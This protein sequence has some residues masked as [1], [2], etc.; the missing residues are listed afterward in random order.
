MRRQSIRRR[1]SSGSETEEVEGI[2]ISSPGKEEE[3]T[4]EWIN[5][6]A[7]SF[8]AIAT[9]TVPT[10]QAPENSNQP[11]TRGYIKR[12]SSMLAGVAPKRLW[13]AQFA[14]KSIPG[15][16]KVKPDLIFCASDPLSKAS[17]TWMEV[18]SFMEV[19]SRPNDPNMTLNLARKAYA[20]FMTQPGRRFLMAVSISAQVFRLHIY[21]RSGVIHSLGYNIHTHADVFSK[22]IYFFTFAQPK[23]LGYDP[24]FIYFDIPRSLSSTP[25]TIRVGTKVYIVVRIIFYSQLIRGRATLCLHVRN[26]QG[27]D[28]VVKDC[29]THQGRKVTEEQILLKLKEHGIHGLPVLKEAWTVQIDGQDDTTDLRRPD[30]LKSSDNYGAMCET[31]I[32]RRYLLQPLGSPITEF[33]CLQEFLSI[34]INIIHGE[35]LRSFSD[36]LT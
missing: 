5:G 1:V 22:L 31:R 9:V 3:D 11:H 19:T 29:W 23:A 14:L 28:F 34:F 7:M 16:I 27:E 13:S 10:V 36:I 18:M 2:F 30:F 20:V 6:L 26:S 4:A 17:P 32:H 33:S 15:A 24:T 12:M 35:C 25:R 21:D 8:Q